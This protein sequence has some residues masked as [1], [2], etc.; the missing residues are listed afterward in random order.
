[1]FYKSTD[2]GNNMYQLYAVEV[3][4]QFKMFHEAAAVEQI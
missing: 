4:F 1:M 3:S 2:R